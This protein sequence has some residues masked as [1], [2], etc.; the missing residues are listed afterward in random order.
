MLRPSG[1][2]VLPFKIKKAS[3]AL[4]IESLFEKTFSMGISCMSLAVWLGEDRKCCATVVGLDLVLGLS[5]V[6][7]CSLK[8]S[9]KRRLVSPMYC[10]LQRL[11]SRSPERTEERL[12]A[13]TPLSLPLPLGT[14]YFMI[15]PYN[16]R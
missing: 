1:S 7:R 8:R 9:F 4:R 14:S 2:I 13:R 3:L 11:T 10:K 5:M 16:N 15:G 6:R 12:G